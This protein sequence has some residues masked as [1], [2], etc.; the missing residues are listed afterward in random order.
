MPM[1]VN[2]EMLATEHYHF[3]CGDA[4][5]N[6]FWPVKARAGEVIIVHSVT[7]FNNCG[8]NFALCYKLMRAKGHIMYMNSVAAI[9]NTVVQRWATDMYLNGN[10][11]C[12]VAVTPNAVND[13]FQVTFQI[14][15]MIDKLYP[16][17]A[18]E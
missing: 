17:L 18:K 5:L 3:I 10:E 2:S 14:I 15:R 9:N 8:A 12:G 6:Y 16:H 13:E 7:I 4:A 11:E 1:L